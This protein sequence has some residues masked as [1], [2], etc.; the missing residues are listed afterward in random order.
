MGLFFFTLNNIT[1]VFNKLRTYLEKEY[2][3]GMDVKIKGGNAR[4]R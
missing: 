2:I 1:S 3:N 4:K